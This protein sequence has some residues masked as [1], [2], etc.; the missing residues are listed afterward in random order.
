M[1]KRGI[2]QGEVDLMLKGKPQ[3]KAYTY[4]ARLKKTFVSG[5]A[6]G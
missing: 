2:L 3:G 1:A 6:A 5:V 4:Q